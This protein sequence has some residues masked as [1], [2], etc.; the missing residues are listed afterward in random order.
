MLDRMRGWIGPR[1]SGNSRSC[2]PASPPVQK[3]PG[4]IWELAALVLLMYLLRYWLSRRDRRAA[5]PTEQGYELPVVSEPRSPVVSKAKPVVV[6]PDDLTAIEGIG[7]KVAGLLNG[8]GIA[9]F[10]QLAGSDVAA[11]KQILKEARLQMIDPATW[12]EQARLASAGEWDALKA[13]QSELKGGRR[14]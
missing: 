14:K 1:T 9:T 5:L 10:A 2:A 11:L 3:V 4:W 12:P 13:L 7:P 8:L 6:A